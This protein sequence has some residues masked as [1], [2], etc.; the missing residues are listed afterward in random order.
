MKHFLSL[1]KKYFSAEQARRLLSVSLEIKENPDL[2]RSALKNKYVGLI[3]EK[4]SLRTKSS[5]YVGTLQLGADPVYYAPGEIQLGS[6]EKAGDVAQA[7][8]R[9]V[10]AVVMRTFSH[11]SMVEFANAA[12]LP[13]INGLSDLL[14]PSQV[15]GDLVTITQAKGDIR[16][17]KL[18]YIGDGNNVCNS[19]L[20]V[21]G[22]L[23]GSI[24]VASPANYGPAEDILR[25]AKKAARDSGA[26]IQ[27]T[28]SALK[29]V[30]DA[31]VLYT[32]VW[33][34]MGQED[35]REKRKKI[36]KNYQI[37]SHLLKAAKPD[38]IVM[39]CLP[40]HRGEEIT[41]EVMDSSQSVVFTQAEDRLHSAKAILLYAFDKV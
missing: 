27:V 34:S 2:Y 15:L 38:A 12:S 21:F 23:G 20:L 32:D 30:A 10:N 13:V 9:F 41:D 35:E 19:L 14:H 26:Q 22:L 29:A 16:K 4:P 31:D 39:H 37:N 28:T 3:F 25:E 8:S 36:F 1:E 33:T 17:V 11:D 24:S 7:L 5:F 40:A 18:A 6:R